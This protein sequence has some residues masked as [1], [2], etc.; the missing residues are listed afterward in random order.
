MAD[1]EGR[2]MRAARILVVDDE[3]QNRKFL[4]RVLAPLGYEIGDACDGN[5]ALEA[6]AKQEPDLVLLDVVMPG[7][8]G[9]EVCRRMKSETR[10]R[11]IPIVMLTGLDRLADRIKGLDLGVDEFLTKPFNVMELTT[12]VR[13]LLSLKHFTDEL[14]HAGLVLTSLA[15]AVEVRDAYTGEHGKR[16]GDNA[17]RVGRA[18]GLDYDELEALRVGGI[19]HDI[20]KIA[21]PD[22]VLRKPGPLTSGEADVMRTHAAAGWD[23]VR[24]MRTLEK[25]LPIIRHHHEHLDGSGYPDGLSGS[26]IPLRVRIISIVDMYDALLTNRPY[27]PALPHE[28]CVS[29]LR[30]EVVRGWWDGEVLETW[31]RLLEKGE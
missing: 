26:A 6:I 16:V 7:V 21:V 17:V 12:R 14:E 24:P 13:S 28:T 30:E 27:K 19:L 8:D 22:S 23:L 3:E 5:E 25:V 15:R 18:L 29:M 9:Y 20:G 11:L 2:T 10:T 1:V 31:I 4:R